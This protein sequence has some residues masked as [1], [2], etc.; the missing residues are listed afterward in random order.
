MPETKGYGG[1]HVDDRRTNP[2]K[3]K[4]GKF[5]FDAHG[6]QKPMGTV[7]LARKGKKNGY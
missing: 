6:P 5:T 3:V 7:S 2:G 1:K 4:S